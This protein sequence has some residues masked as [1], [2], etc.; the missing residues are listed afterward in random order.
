MNVK[1]SLDLLMGR[2][3]GRTRPTL[4]TTC[5][6]EMVLFQQNECEG[7][8]EL[9]WFIITE[10]AET[11][12]EAPVDGVGE[13]RIP[14]PT[15]F[16]REVEDKNLAYVSEDGAI[17]ELRRVG[18]EELEL[19]FLNAEP[20]TPEVYSMHGNYIYLGP[21]PDRVITIY[22]PAYY[23]RQEPP[24]DSAESENP[25]FQ[26]ASDLMIAGAGIQVASLHLQNP[27][28]V[29]LMAASLVR[30][31]DRLNKVITAREEANRVRR[32]G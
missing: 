19:D 20:G 7:G 10:R 31:R 5:L 26:W 15:D 30:A 27:G 29:E 14:L 23:A 13:P 11:D 6:E 3:G 18:Y 17:I 21:A 8:E 4:R 1:R 22:Y 32:M 16:I 2:L 25:W 28:L 24:S 12:T 9:P